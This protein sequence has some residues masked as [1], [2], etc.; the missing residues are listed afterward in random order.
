MTDTDAG[1]RPTPSTTSDGAAEG[2]GPKPRRR[3][4]RG[5]RNRNRPRSDAATASDSQDDD[6]AKTIESVPERLSPA[7]DV[8]ATPDEAADDKT[9]RVTAEPDTA[10]E[11]APVDTARMKAAEPTDTAKTIEEAELKPASE[12]AEEKPLERS[13]AVDADKA[14]EDAIARA[15][16]AEVEDAPVRKV[17]T[18]KIAPLPENRPV[19][20]PVTVVGTVTDQGTVRSDAKPQDVALADRSTRAETETAPVPAG[21]YVVQ[22]ASLPS[23]AEAK[24]SYARLSAKFSGII[25]GRGV[26]IRKAEIK[27]KGTYYR[28]R[29]PAGSKQEAQ[30]LC[31]DYKKAGG[32]CLVSR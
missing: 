12:T 2:S 26:D 24:T 30:S 14:S 25:G 9:A 5:G 32:S 4:S 18:T 31:A 19:D 8:A 28:V 20:Q 15:A 10:A 6:I 7:D 27:N 22:I 1:D 23:E 21:S 13:I 29:I 17:K 3:G 11:T 16:D